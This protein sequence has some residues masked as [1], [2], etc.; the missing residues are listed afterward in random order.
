MSDDIRADLEAAM[1]KVS[2]QAAEDADTGGDGAAPESAADGLQGSEPQGGATGD[3]GTGRSLALES[4][5]QRARDERGRFAQGRHEEKK[6]QAVTPKVTVRPT[7]TPK[8]SPTV[9]SAT[10]TPSPAVQT[11]TLRPPQSWKPAA[12]EHFAR[13]PPEVQAEVLRREKETAMALQESAPTRKEAEAWRNALAPFE[14]QIRAEGGEPIAAVQ[15]LLQTAAALRGPNAHVVMAQI[16]KN[17][18]I[19]LQKLDAV[20][21]GEAPQQAHQQLGPQDIDRAVDQRLQDRVHR[22]LATKA[23]TDVAKFAQENEF[24]E[25]VRTDMQAMM[26]AAA[27]RGVAMNLGD[28]YSRACWAN[29]EVRSILQQREA[30]KTANERLAS[31]H[32]AR[33][34]ASSVRT[35]PAG[36]SPESKPGDLRSEIEAAMAAVGGRR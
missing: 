27:Q 32:S 31:T 35:Q 16:I 12:R 18:G 11:E 17:S 21:A 7:V 25:D 1:E 24:F 29:E 10:P 26:L 36:A 28:A 34:A 19:D 14:A 6:P 2:G 5:A 20:L 3:E 4:A 33:N 23:T 13:L 30:A 22:A 8:P 15:N 9:S